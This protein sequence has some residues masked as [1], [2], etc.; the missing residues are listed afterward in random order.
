MTEAAKQNMRRAYI[1]HND[2]IMVVMI[3]VAMY[4]SMMISDLKKHDITM[5]KYDRHRVSSVQ[6]RKSYKR[7]TTN[8]TITD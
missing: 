2:I 7:S 8:I 4:M 1:T 5:S 6:F 3:N